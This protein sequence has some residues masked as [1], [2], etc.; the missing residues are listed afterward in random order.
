MP[1]SIYIYI[2]LYMG[3]VLVGTAVIDLTTTALGT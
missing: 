3:Y 2:W 1:G